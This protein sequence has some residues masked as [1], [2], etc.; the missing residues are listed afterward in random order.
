MI[1]TCIYIHKSTVLL[2]LSELNSTGN[3]MAHLFRSQ[4]AIVSTIGKSNLKVLIPFWA[5]VSDSDSDSVFYFFSFIMFCV[6]VAV[7]VFELFARNCRVLGTCQLIRQK[8]SCPS[9]QSIFHTLWSCSMR[10]YLKLFVWS[11]FASR[12]ANG[13]FS[14]FGKEHSSCCQDFGTSGFLSFWIS[15]FHDSRTFLLF[16]FLK[17]GVREHFL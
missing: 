12:P 15:G 10:H 6:S 13:E 14:L 8:P 4:T 17:G 9:S 5:P 1:Y 3:S 7:C 16:F 2:G 11:E